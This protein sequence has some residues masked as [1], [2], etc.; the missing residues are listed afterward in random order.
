MSCDSV[1]GQNVI[2][3]AQIWNYWWLREIKSEPMYREEIH[4]F[5]DFRNE[6]IISLS[7]FSTNRRELRHI[8]W[9]EMT[10]HSRLWWS[11]DNRPLTS[12]SS[13]DQTTASCTVAKKQSR[14][15]VYP[16]RGP[17][18]PIKTNHSNQLMSMTQRSSTKK[19]GRVRSYF[20]SG[21]H[22]IRSQC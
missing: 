19:K 15:Y 18:M 4:I 22:K 3:K 17:L 6:P 9:L 13:V 21:R 2:D 11:C 20:S 5:Q 8:R 12:K 10:S 7:F 1:G 16:R 14:K